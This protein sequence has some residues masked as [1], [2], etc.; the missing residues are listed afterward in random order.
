M[1]HNALACTFSTFLVSDCE[2]M[3][4]TTGQYKKLK[5]INGLNI[6]SFDK[7]SIVDNNIKQ[8]T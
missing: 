6:V 7:G 1:K 4:Q 3:C 5:T 2:H 8:L